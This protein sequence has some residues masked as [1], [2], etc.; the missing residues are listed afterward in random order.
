MREPDASDELATPIKKGR[1]AEITQFTAKPNPDDAGSFLG[2][3]TV[4]HVHLD[5]LRAG[6]Y[7]PSSSTGAWGPLSPPAPARVPGS[8]AQGSFGV[9]PFDGSKAVHRAP[10]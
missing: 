1:V 9:D 5:G 6:Y 2:T 8:S 10:W 3:F 7:I 4:R